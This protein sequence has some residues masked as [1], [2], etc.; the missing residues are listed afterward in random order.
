MYAS[1]IGKIQYKEH[2]N[3]RKSN[4][5][6]VSFTLAKQTNEKK[7]RRKHCKKRLIPTCTLMHKILSK[8]YVSTLMMQ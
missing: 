6:D 5:T 7:K 8:T 3:F 1:I 4:G 2:Q